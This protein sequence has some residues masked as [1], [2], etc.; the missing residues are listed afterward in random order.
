MWTQ[1][2]L[3][4]DLHDIGLTGGKVA[5]VH[6]SMRAVGEME[7]GA[8]TLVAAFR[9][10]LGSEGTLLVPTFTPENRDPDERVSLGSVPRM[11]VFAETVLQQ[12]DAFR[13]DHPLYSF[14]AVGAQAAALTQNAPFHYP[15]GSDS[16]LARLHQLNGWVLLIGVGHAVNCS[17]HLAEVWANVPYVHRSATVVTGTEET[18]A[19]L[20]SPD[21]SAGFPRI[22]SLLRQSRI[23]RSGYI[24]NAESQLM[25]QQ[26]AVSMAV[27]MLT[28]QASALLCED[29]T[30]R[31]CTLARRMTAD[32]SFEPI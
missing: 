29:E 22:E 11:G 2:Q 18:K 30:C 4:E 21:C 19:M 16:P 14:T 20:G 25:R 17:L 23:L 1:R 13:S 8:Q 24:G 3:T 26:Q 10:A 6:A 7:A 9:E 28:G 27:A 12:P 32:Q 5:L 15:V 31:A